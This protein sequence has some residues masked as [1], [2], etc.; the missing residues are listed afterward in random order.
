MSMNDEDIDKQIVDQLY[1]DNRVKASDV[2][3]TVDKGW[4]TL[5]GEVPSY[6]AKTTAAEDAYLVR[7]V[8]FVD[9]KLTV[10]YPSF[11]SDKEIK[12]NVETSLDWDF[13][14][15]A[16]KITVSADEGT[17]KLLGTVDAYWKKMLAEGDAYKITGV[18]DIKNELAIVTTDKWTD[19]M[20]AKDI[21]EALR[22]NL[23]VE[24]ND[25]DVKVGKGRVTLSGEVPDWTA[26][27]AADTSALYTAGVKS[28]HNMLSIA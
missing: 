13:D 3:V 27:Y 7:G 15:D 8:K 26:R 24:V 6:Q 14:I 5:K 10:A 9:N 4:V 28:V 22:R 11:P 12:E 16:S 20:I 1:W 17:V 19:E 18:M 2:A 25:V 23:N 21:E